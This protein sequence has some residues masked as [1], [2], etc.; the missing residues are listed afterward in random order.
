MNNAELAPSLWLYAIH[1]R[2]YDIIHFLEANDIIPEDQSLVHILNPS[3][4]E[5][6]NYF[7]CYQCA[8][9]SEIIIP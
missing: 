3:Y 2:N 8:L 7:T 6:I 5:L 1:G 9:L 4:V